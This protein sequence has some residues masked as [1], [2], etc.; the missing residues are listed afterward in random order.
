MGLC[1]QRVKN[2]AKWPSC[3]IYDAAILQG[4]VLGGG[5]AAVL[6]GADADT[7]KGTLTFPAPAVAAHPPETP[8]HL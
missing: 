6:R 5:P 8:I 4:A 7:L 2:D 3:N 1:C